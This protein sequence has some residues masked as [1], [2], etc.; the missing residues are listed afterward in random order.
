MWNARGNPSHKYVTSIG[1]CEWRRCLFLRNIF[2][3][4]GVKQIFK[5]MTSS[6]LDQKCEI[7]CFTSNI[8][9]SGFNRIKFDN[10]DSFCWA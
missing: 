1:C 2:I 9:T 6:T 8:G 5:Q 10:P 4:N 3:Y 7:W